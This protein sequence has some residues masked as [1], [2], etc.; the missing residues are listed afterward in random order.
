[1]LK[2]VPPMTEIQLCAESQLVTDGATLWLGGWR[3]RRWKT[4]KG[5]PIKNVDLWQP[6]YDT[7][8]S[9][10]AEQEW[11]KVP[12]HVDLEG[13]KKADELADEGVKKHGVW[14]AA[15]GSRKRPAAKR[16][17]HQRSLREQQARRQGVEEDPQQPRRNPQPQPTNPTLNPNPA[18]N[19]VQVNIYPNLVLVLVGN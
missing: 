9:R 6:L 17:E 1:M 16:P 7:L 4:K 2:L 3:R 8:Q 10:R 18:P 14:L 13:N 5:Q 12:S 19:P 11:A 15:E